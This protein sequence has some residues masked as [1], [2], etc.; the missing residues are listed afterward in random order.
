[1]DLRNNGS[2]RGLRRVLIVGA[3][4][5]GPALARGLAARGVAAEMIEVRALATEPGAGLLLTGNAL[6]ALDALGVGPAVRAAG[7][8]VHSVRF[9]DFEDRELFRIPVGAARGWPDF[10]SIHRASLRRVLLEPPESPSL[11]FDVTLEAVESHADGVRVRLSSGESREYDLVVG[12]DGV[13]SRVRE[14]AFATP[15]QA[16]IAGFAGWRFVAPAHTAVEEPT[17]FLGNGRTLL[18]HPLRDGDVYCGAGPVDTSVLPSDGADLERLRAAFADL[19]GPAAQF[20]AAL[21]PDLRPFP[22][23][24]WEVAQASW[25]RGR[26]LLIGD[27]AHACAPTLAQGA[28]MAFEDA[29]VLSELLASGREIDAALDAF[30]LRRRARVERVQQGSRARI[31]ANRVQGPRALRVR[32]RVLRAVGGRRLEEAWAPLVAWR[33]ER[34]EERG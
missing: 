15:A 31:E 4:L 13:A 17:Y 28:A 27:A 18:L 22:T 25:R 23:R 19:A 5:A 1:M 14:L 24:Y 20:L 30:E 29:V 12:A 6:V 11:R 32:D 34:R 7:R 8:I 26:C 33:P 2:M 16:P 9:A 21:S 3:G 10:V